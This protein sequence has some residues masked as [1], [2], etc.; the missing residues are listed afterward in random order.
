MEYASVQVELA[1]LLR[2][3]PLGTTA[4]INNYTVA[5]WGGREVRGF[6]IGRDDKRIEEEFDFDERT[7]NAL[8]ADLVAWMAAP[9]Y[10]VRP[11]L[12]QRLK[13]APWSNGGA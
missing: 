9:R 11:E 2:S 12:A 5:Y 3:R 10:T 7:C 1:T 6:R 4:D 13:G 8:H